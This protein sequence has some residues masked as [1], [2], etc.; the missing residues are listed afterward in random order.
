MAVEGARRILGGR[1]LFIAFIELAPDPDRP[2]RAPRRLELPPAERP[3]ELTEP[4]GAFI[5]FLFAMATLKR[6]QVRSQAM[7]SNINSMGA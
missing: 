7:A 3:L 2:E 1:P 5:A 4:L 6:R